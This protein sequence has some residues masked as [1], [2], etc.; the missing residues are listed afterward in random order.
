VLQNGTVLQTYARKERDRE[1]SELARKSA[2]WKNKGNQ[3]KPDTCSSNKGVKQLAFL[4]KG[5]WRMMKGDC[6]R[7]EQHR[8]RPH[9]KQQ[10]PRLSTWTSR[11]IMA[12]KTEASK[13]LEQA[14]PV[15]QQ[16]D[17]GT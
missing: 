6:K 15:N 17:I 4:W 1:G 10:G 9:K 16:R 8:E 14:D 2:W 3:T 11:K 13:G 5:M 12:S 7:N